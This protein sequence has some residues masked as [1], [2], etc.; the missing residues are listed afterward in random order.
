MTDFSKAYEYL[1]KFHP[2]QYEAY[3]ADRNAR[4]LYELA[5]PDLWLEMFLAGDVVHWTAPPSSVA[6]LSKKTNQEPTTP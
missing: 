5:P 1:R 4:G 6:D 2:E 3:T